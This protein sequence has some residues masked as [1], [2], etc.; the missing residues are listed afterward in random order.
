M[1]GLLSLSPPSMNVPWPGILCG[2]KYLLASDFSQAAAACSTHQGAADV[3]R[4]LSR[5]VSVKLLTAG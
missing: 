4:A 2:V 1:Q 3:H 5:Q